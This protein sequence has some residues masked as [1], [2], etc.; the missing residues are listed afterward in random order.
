MSKMAKILFPLDHDWFVHVSKAYAKEN[1][2][3]S[4][5]KQL[6]RDEKYPEGITNGAQWYFMYLFISEWS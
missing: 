1:K 4:S 6:C 5:G 3:M 2:H